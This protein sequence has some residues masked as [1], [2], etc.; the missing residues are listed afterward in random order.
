MREINGVSY[1]SEKEAALRFGYSCSWFNLM[2]MQKK[3]PSYV[4]LGGRVLYPL[5]KTDDW[6]KSQIEY[7]DAS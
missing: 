6:F 4:K 1:I 3:G 2:R 5:K 7:F